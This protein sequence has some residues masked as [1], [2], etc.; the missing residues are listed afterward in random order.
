ME[1]SGNNLPEFLSGTFERSLG[2][3]GRIALPRPWVGILGRKAHLCRGSTGVLSVWPDFF[4]MQ[5]AESLNVRQVT[6]MDDTPEARK[7]FSRSSALSIRANGR[8][9]IPMEE[10]S[11]ARLG[12]RVVLVACGN[13]FEIYPYERWLGMEG[14]SQHISSERS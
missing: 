1:S 2:P 11:R 8:F 4:W 12:D 13:R 14:E 5:R 6:E 7:F 10:R 3:D 9:V